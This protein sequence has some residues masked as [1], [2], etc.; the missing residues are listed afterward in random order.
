MLKANGGC[1]EQNAALAQGEGPE[2]RAGVS[3]IYSFVTVGYLADR[4]IDNNGL[5]NSSL[6]ISGIGIASFF[7]NRRRLL[8]QD[9]HTIRKDR[10]MR[11]LTLIKP[12][13]VTLLVLCA[14]RAPIAHAALIELQPDA[15]LAE[16]GDSIALELLVSGLGNFGPDS[17]GAFDI[18]VGYDPSRLSFT[19]YSLGDLLGDN[20]LADAIDAS[21]G[22]VGGAVNLAEV[23]LLSAASLDALQPDAFVLATLQFDVINLSPSVVTQ[24][25]VLAGPVL[26]DA[27]ASPIAVTGLGSASVT[28]VPVPG[29]LLL[30]T[31]SV[32][33]WLTTRR[34]YAV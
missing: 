4:H 11:A 9:L 28:G 5:K 10:Y 26:A 2:T 25:S 27:F 14:L 17:L 33:G 24:L 6:L 23:S 22:D 34:R 18:S 19:G 20:G 12:M 7:G 1:G 31:A 32:F 3:F 21:A 8:S 15:L 30:L 29:T 16:T 13:F